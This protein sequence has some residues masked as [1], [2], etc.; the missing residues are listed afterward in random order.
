V[1]LVDVIVFVLIVTI[2]CYHTIGRYLAL[3][4]GSIRAGQNSPYFDNYMQQG[5]Y[6]PGK[7][8][9]SYL[10]VL[11]FQTYSGDD[12]RHKFLNITTVLLPASS[13][14]KKFQC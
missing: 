7:Y 13:L 14:H 12:C 1:S 11:Y 9:F 6:G 3:P 8:D 5:K 4:T 2:V 10:P